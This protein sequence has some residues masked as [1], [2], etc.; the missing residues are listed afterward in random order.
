MSGTVAASVGTH[1]E[2][3]EGEIHGSE[4]FV[5]G[6][7]GVFRRTEFDFW[8]VLGGIHHP[9]VESRRSARGK[10]RLA[11]RNAQRSPT[12]HSSESTVKGVEFLS[13]ALSLSHFNSKFKRMSGRRLYVGRLDADATRKDVEDYFSTHG[14]IVDV[15]LMAGFC[16]LEY[17]ELKVSQ[18]R[19][20]SGANSL[21]RSRNSGCGTSCRRLLRKRVY[22][23][24]LDRRVR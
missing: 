12:F 11:I 17:Q 21:T 3:R 14:P 16:F 6:E 15:R 2:G 18:P 1:R 8:L 13:F 24:A 10:T 20:H 7:E 22:E 4:F 19:H 5:R 9:V 23:P